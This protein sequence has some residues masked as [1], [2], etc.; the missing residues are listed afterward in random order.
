MRNILSADAENNNFND[1][2][3]KFDAAKTN[4][5]WELLIKETVSREPLTSHQRSAIVARCKNQIAGTYGKT[6]TAAHMSHSK[7]S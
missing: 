3:N 7:T 1:L 6:K 5:E 4:E 2:L